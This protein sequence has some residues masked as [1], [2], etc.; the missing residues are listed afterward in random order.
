[1]LT[2]R[3]CILFILGSAVAGSIAQPIPAERLQRLRQLPVLCYHN[4]RQDAVTA[5]QLYIS[6]L[7]LKRQL[8]TLRDSGF[9]SVLPD[10]VHAFYYEGTPLPSKAFL[11]T[12]DDAH[13]QHATLAA[14]LL[15]R[16]GFRGVFFIMS[17][18]LNKKGF[19]NEQQIKEL[20]Q[21]GHTIGA[22]TWDHPN[23]AK[24]S[25]VNWNLQLTKP[26]QQLERITGKPVTSFAYPYG[27]W[28]RASLQELNRRG[29]HTAF[30]LTNA[31]DSAHPLLTLRRLMIHGNWS[32]PVLLTRL[33]SVFQ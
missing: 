5:N 2:L 3:F 20:H 15:E 18:T 6:T 27:A 11:I 17:V 8:Q 28:N 32:G 22:H 7:Q 10:Q 4:I 21:R 14:P 26:K 12:F 19:L 31:M 33:Q 16:Y 30:Q 1:M 25:S 9:Q 13:L 24:S 29:I 23:L